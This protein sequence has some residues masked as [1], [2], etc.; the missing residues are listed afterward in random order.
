MLN[1]LSANGPV[2]FLKRVEQAA[3]KGMREGEVEGGKRRWGRWGGGGGL[4]DPSRAR[5]ELGVVGDGGMG[6][7]EQWER[8]ITV[9]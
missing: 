1:M 4:G 9:V 7:G 6:L 8:L 2:T 5:D 3:R